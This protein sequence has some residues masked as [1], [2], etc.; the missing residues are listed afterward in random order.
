MV[1]KF[2]LIW[3]PVTRMGQTTVLVNASCQ[4]VFTSPCF[5]P[6]DLLAKRWTHSGRFEVFEIK[7]CWVEI[8]DIILTWGTYQSYHIRTRPVLFTNLLAC[9]LLVTVCLPMF[10]FK[11]VKYISE[12]VAIYGELAMNCYLN[13]QQQKADFCILDRKRCF[14]LFMLHLIIA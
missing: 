13:K 6:E 11:L 12:A 5:S 8:L 3:C 14:C 4:R 2:V 1:D 7:P 9:S 10:V